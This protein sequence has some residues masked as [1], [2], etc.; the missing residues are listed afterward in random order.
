MERILGGLYIS[1]YPHL[2]TNRAECEENNITHL[3]SVF[4]GTFPASFNKYT[5]HS[6][7]VDDLES[8]NI[9]EWFDDANDF[10]N[11]ALF[12]GQTEIQR[13]VKGKHE[14][15]LVV[16]C[17]AGESRSVVILASYL[18]KKYNLTP[19]QA[20]HAIQR[21]RPHIHPNHSFRKQLTLYYA[22]DCVCDKSNPMFRQWLL[23]HSTK[24]DTSGR[25]LMVDDSMFT[26]DSEIVDQN[27]KDL[28]QLR[29]KRCR[30]AL[31]LSS[32]FV[33][34]VP[35]GEESKQSSFI[36]KVPNS[37]RVISVQSASNTCSHFFVEPLNWMKPELQDKQELEGKFQC[38]K[39]ETKVGGY[40]WKGSRCSC[41]KWMVPA[42]HLQRAKVDEIKLNHQ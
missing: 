5:L 28:T 23:Q 36:R 16:I 7:P 17:Q 27:D 25:G 15:N 39:C 11:R 9:I 38:P 21:K 10:I 34:H 42:I 35:P 32:S 37:K 6:I 29:C 18:M 41:G 30:Q 33:G 14:N 4:K 19:E 8:T 40:N 22:M 3:V 1:S 24:T 31:A 26:D 20:L 2:L 12:P 13:G